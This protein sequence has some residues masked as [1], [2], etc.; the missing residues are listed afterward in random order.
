MPP[1]KKIRLESGPKQGKLKNDGESDIPSEFEI[2]L[3]AR[4]SS[5]EDSTVTSTISV[6]SASS[7]N[8]V[9][10]PIEAP[11]LN[12]IESVSNPR[13]SH[14]PLEST[15]PRFLPLHLMKK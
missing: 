1:N 15:D 9:Q 10:I 4:P 2:A 6:P 8:F 12:Q 14:N 3:S 5:L 7:S 11:V 13:V